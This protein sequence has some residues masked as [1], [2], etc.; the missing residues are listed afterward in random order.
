VHPLDSD[1]NISAEFK[2]TIS[3]NA[4]V[5]HDPL[6]R[7][8]HEALLNVDQNDDTAVPTYYSSQRTI[9]RKRKKNDT[10]PIDI[11]LKRAR[12]LFNF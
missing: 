3:T 9:E 8:I 5:S 10:I 1:E 2:A 4:T 6:R 7:I 11:Y 12:A